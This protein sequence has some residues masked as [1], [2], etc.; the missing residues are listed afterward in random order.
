MQSGKDL[1]LDVSEVYDF[2]DNDFVSSHT[3]Y[4]KPQRIRP[5]WAT[6]LKKGLCVFVITVLVICYLG[7]PHGIGP[8]FLLECVTNMTDFMVRPCIY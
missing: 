4:K 6:T 5:C 7:L 1:L 3:R 2:E 8:F